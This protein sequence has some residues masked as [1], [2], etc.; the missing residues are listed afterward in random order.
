MHLDD[1]DLDVDLYKTATGSIS[2]DETRVN[3]ENKLIES[4]YKI[5]VASRGE[6][7]CFGTDDCGGKRHNKMARGSEALIREDY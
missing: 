5:G 6:L 3:G 7:T 2:V 1:L 4:G